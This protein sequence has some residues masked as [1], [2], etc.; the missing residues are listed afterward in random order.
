MFEWTFRAR[1]TTVVFGVVLAGSVA[2]FWSRV[3]GAGSL[4]I[5][6]GVGVGMPVLVAGSPNL[7]GEGYLAAT[8]PTERAGD[9]AVT[10]GAALAAGL[11]VALT[12]DVVLDPPVPALLGAVAAVLGGQVGFFGRNREF[13]EVDAATGDGAESG[14]AG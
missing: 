10:A 6:V 9:A 1:F 13:L 14:E 12:L 7:D 2:S 5:V 3:L 11:V 4:A 8:T